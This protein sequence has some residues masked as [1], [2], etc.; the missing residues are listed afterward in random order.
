M[1]HIIQDQ[2]NG[3]DMIHFMPDQWNDKT[4]I[5]L[6]HLLLQVLSLTCLRLNKRFVLNISIGF[7]F[8]IRDYWQDVDLV[9]LLH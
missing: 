7:A 1:I 3:N 9:L 8:F 4:P 6:H 2:W 5:I